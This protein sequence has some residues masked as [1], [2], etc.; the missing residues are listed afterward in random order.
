MEF[1]PTISNQILLTKGKLNIKDQ[2]KLFFKL[3]YTCTMMYWYLSAAL[4]SRLLQYRAD[5]WLSCIPIHGDIHPWPWIFTCRVLEYV[6]IYRYAW[7]LHAW[8]SPP[9]IWLWNSYFLLPDSFLAFGIWHMAGMSIWPI[10]NTVYCNNM[11]IWIL[12]YSI[13]QYLPSTR[14]PVLSIVGTL[15]STRVLHVYCNTHVYVLEYV[16]YNIMAYCNT[17]V[18]TVYSSVLQ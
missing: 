9:R 16:E 5:A 10:C 4:R 15:Y 18:D 12:Q 13:L 3:V 1:N 17:R 8:L 11:A 14:V 6:S 7:P 2:T